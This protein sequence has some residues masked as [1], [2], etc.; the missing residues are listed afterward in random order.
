MEENSVGK[1]ESFFTPSNFLRAQN[2]NISFFFHNSTTNSS[3]VGK[4]PSISS[5]HTHIN[6]TC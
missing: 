2:H 3:T 1:E 5:Q 4:R 6:I